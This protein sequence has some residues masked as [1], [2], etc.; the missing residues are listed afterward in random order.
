MSISALR[1]KNFGTPKRLVLFINVTIL[2]YGHW[3]LA[4]L[5]S[6]DL[7]SRAVGTQG[8]SLHEWR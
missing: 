1:A 7:I 8:Q 2:T 4:L 6:W 5:H 3:F